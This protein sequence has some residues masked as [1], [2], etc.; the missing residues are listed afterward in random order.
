MKDLIIGVRSFISNNQYG[1]PVAA[2]GFGFLICCLFYCCSKCCSKNNQKTIAAENFKWPNSRVFLK[3]TS[4][5]DPPQLIVPKYSDPLRTDKLPEGEEQYWTMLVQPNG[6]RVEVE[7]QMYLVFRDGIVFGVGYEAVRKLCKIKG[8]YV[9]NTRSNQ[10]V[11]A[12]DCWFSNDRDNIR[13]HGTGNGT[14][15][16]GN[17]FIHEIDPFSS[18]SGIPKVRKFFGDKFKGSFLLQM[19][20]GMGHHHLRLML[21]TRR[22]HKFAK[23]CFPDESAPMP[24]SPLGRYSEQDSPRTFGDTDSTRDRNGYSA[25]AQTG[26]TSKFRRWWPTRFP[27]KGRRNSPVEGRRG[28][29]ATEGLNEEK[30]PGVELHEKPA[31]AR[32][33]SS[34][35]EASPTKSLSRHSASGRKRGLSGAGARW[36]KTGGNI[37]TLNYLEVDGIPGRSGPALV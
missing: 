29:T 19:N 21:H 12:M 20:S 1:V 36:P 33:I 30:S 25:V 3:K 31:W 32:N 28:H 27:R 7:Q 13:L 35:R 9:Y 5:I 37:N 8:K 15:I 2:G 34:S 10:I 23:E 16:V 17:C 26:R 22:V 24:T 4:A 14:A 18:T 11:L 6:E